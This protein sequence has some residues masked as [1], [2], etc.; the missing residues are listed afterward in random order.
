M[1][2]SGATGL[3]TA[4][5]ENDTMHALLYSLPLAGVTF[6]LRE[7]NWSGKIIVL[8]LFVGSMFAWSI[9]LTKIKEL[10]VARRMSR[11]FLQAYRKEGHPAALFIRRQH[12]DGS[13]LNDIY[14]RACTALGAAFESRGVDPNDLFMGAVGATEHHLNEIQVSGVRNVSERTLADQALLLENSMGFIATAITT[15]PFLGLLGTVWGVMDAFGGMAVSGSAML[16]AV[17]PGISSALLTTVV[18]LLVAL[19]SAIG[20]NILSDQIR[21]LSVNM[22][23][24]VQEFMAD[25]EHHYL[26]QR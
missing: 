19:P 26:L 14:Q 22:D 3:A 15:A 9:M 16:S 2:Q 4:P 12:F 1:G 5:D 25:V 17:A 23:N 8:V 21:R 13:P 10:R 6:A 24:F 20:Y 11:R 18:G 7:S